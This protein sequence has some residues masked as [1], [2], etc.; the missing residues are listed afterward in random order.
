MTDDL[1]VLSHCFAPI[2]RRRGYFQW[3]ADKA[4]ERERERR[5]GRGRRKEGRDRKLEGAKEDP[6]CSVSDLHGVNMPTVAVFKLPM[7]S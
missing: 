4:T 1:H 3:C 7:V 2:A 6:I 5:G